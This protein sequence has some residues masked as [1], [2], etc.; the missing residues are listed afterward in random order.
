[1]SMS[2]I[3][4][5]TFN[6]FQLA[7]TSNPYQQQMQQL[8][9]ALQSGNLSAAQSD[10]STLQQ[11]FSQPATTTGP[12]SSSNSGGNSAT[13][14]PIN[15]AFNQL[16]SDLQS[17]NISAAQKDFSGVQQDMNGHGTVSAYRLLRPGIGGASGQNSP[18]Q[19]LNQVG[20]SL[21]SSNLAAAQQTYASL[22]QQLQQFAFGGETLSNESPIS[23]NA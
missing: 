14:A 13:L 8:S 1:M 11:A 21:T 6:P 5:S 12:A 16:A 2:G 23:F 7:A 9:Q 18:L 17:G 20:Q 3:Q 4:S 19:E 15:Q 10:F 22:Q